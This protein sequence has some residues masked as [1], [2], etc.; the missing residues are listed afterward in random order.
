MWIVLHLDS[1]ISNRLVE[2][3][4]YAYLPDRNASCL[5]KSLRENKT[6]LLTLPKMYKCKYSEKSSQHLGFLNC[7]VKP[8]GV[9]EKRVNLRVHWTQSIFPITGT[10]ALDG[11]MLTCC[12][13]FTGC[14]TVLPVPHSAIRNGPGGC[15]RAKIH[16]RLL[17]GLDL[18]P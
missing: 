10:P 3:G 5:S 6:H 9:P 12:E 18:I 7:F 11:F 2:G 13:H 4:G 8:K 16:R 14:L 17:T 15:W 1:L